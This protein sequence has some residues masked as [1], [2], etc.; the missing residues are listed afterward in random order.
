[1]NSLKAFCIYLDYF[2]EKN[3]SK[4]SHSSSK[5][6]SQHTLINFIILQ[7]IFVWYK[8]SK[9]IDYPKEKLDS[10]HMNCCLIVKNFSDILKVFH[11]SQ[12]LISMFGVFVFDQ[13]I[14]KKMCH[15]TSCIYTDFIMFAVLKISFI[16]S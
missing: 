15:Y 5:V 13:D 12:L 8:E 7:S 9:F 6:I 16:L 1:M 10:V 14:W 3:V 11:R 2:A 4:Y